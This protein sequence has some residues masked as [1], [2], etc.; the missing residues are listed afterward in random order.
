MSAREG[1]CHPLQ[2]P[3]PDPA[4]P[5]AWSSSLSPGPG[6]TQKGTKGRSNPGLM[7]GHWA[8]PAPLG[9]LP[10]WMGQKSRDKS[11]L[12]AQR[13]EQCHRQTSQRQFQG[14]FNTPSFSPPAV[15]RARLLLCRG[16]Q[17]GSCCAVP[18]GTCQILLLP[19][20]ALPAAVSFPTPQSAE[21]LPGACFPWRDVVRSC[22]QG[23]LLEEGQRK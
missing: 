10:P 17:P 12:R 22:S 1:I 5:G 14:A 18:A 20:A 23:G 9:S 11:C 8:A 6:L 21:Q 19:E 3:L 16:L 4:S 7:A 15:P 13:G 2:R